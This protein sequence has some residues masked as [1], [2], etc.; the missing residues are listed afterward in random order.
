MK[1]KVTNII[2][3]IVAC[4]I[5]SLGYVGVLYASFARYID[6]SKVQYI[7]EKMDISEID[8]G[9]YVSVSLYE[10]NEEKYESYFICLGYYEDDII[11]G[12]GDYSYL[13]EGLISYS[14][15]YQEGLYWVRYN[16]DIVEE[17]EINTDD[18][19]DYIYQFDFDYSLCDK[20]SYVTL[21]NLAF[22]FEKNNLVYTYSFDKDYTC[23]YSNTRF[24]EKYELTNLKLVVET[25]FNYK[26]LSIC[27][28][29]K[30]DSKDIMLRFHIA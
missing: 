16:G 10:E 27:F 22:D 17:K 19:Y 28:Y 21:K 30:S 11:I 12:G 29:G 8:P 6:D 24:E 3:I 23:S 2:K 18:I 5:I 9:D 13:D 4:L 1:K 20:P 26:P 7:I 14:W 25:D 15:K